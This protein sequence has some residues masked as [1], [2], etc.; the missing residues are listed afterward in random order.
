[1]KG[2]QQTPNAQRRTSNVELREA[3]LARE[4]WPPQPFISWSENAIK[5]R[6]QLAGFDL[7]RTIIKILDH[8]GR[9]WEQQSA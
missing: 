1:M 4:E 7:E 6:L 5:R 9:R 2:K 3:D 8:Q